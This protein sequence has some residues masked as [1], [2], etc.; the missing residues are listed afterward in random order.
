LEEIKLTY[1]RQVR[2]AEGFGG[3]GMGG[4]T[5]GGYQDE[6]PVTKEIPRTCCRIPGFVG[7]PPVSDSFCPTPGLARASRTLTDGLLKAVGVDAVGQNQYSPCRL[8][9]MGRPTPVESKNT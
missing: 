8:L 6:C 9:P 5:G 3:R 1:T 4:C 7:T 2:A